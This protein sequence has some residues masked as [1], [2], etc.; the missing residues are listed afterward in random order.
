MATVGS[1]RRAEAA[2]GELQPGDFVEVTGNVQYKGETGVVDYLAP[3]QKF[4]VVRLQ[5]GNKASFHIS[6][7]TQADEDDDTFEENTMKF[8]TNQPRQVTRESLLKG[9]KAYRKEELEDDKFYLVVDPDSP[10]DASIDIKGGQIFFGPFDSPEDAATAAGADDA[11]VVPGDDIDAVDGA[12][13]DDG[14]GQVGDMDLGESGRR[15][16]RRPAAPARR[17]AVATETSRLRASVMRDIMREA[18]ALDVDTTIK[19][20][21][22][23]T[24]QASGAVDQTGVNDGVTNQSASEI[25]QQHVQTDVKADDEPGFEGSD[26][27]VKPSGAGTLDSNGGDLGSVRESQNASTTDNGVLVEKTNPKY[28]TPGSFVRVYEGHGAGRKKVD[29]GVVFKMTA[30][31]VTLDGDA[32]YPVDKY[33]FIL[34]AH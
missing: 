30:E 34:M 25:G 14:Q 29:Q 19:S 18:D 24:D 32:E 6:D 27:I 26:S 28:C 16:V 33:S 5:S 8:R 10:G 3:S 11:N 12:L 21:D 4:A 13:A 31:A 17:A 1:R 20:G 9:K 2:D 22:Q 23:A 7:L 15:G